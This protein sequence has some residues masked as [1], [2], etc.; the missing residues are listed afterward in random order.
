MHEKK[1]SECLWKTR[2]VSL[3]LFVSLN[4]SFQDGNSS[5]SVLCLYAPCLQ[6]PVARRLTLC[7]ESEKNE[8]IGLT[9]ELGWPRRISPRVERKFCHRSQWCGSS[10]FL[11]YSMTVVIFELSGVWACIPDSLKVAYLSFTSFLAKFMGSTHGNPLLK[12]SLSLNAFW[13]PWMWYDSF[14]VELNPCFMM[15][16]EFVSQMLS[17]N[18]I[19]QLCHGSTYVGDRSVSDRGSLMEEL[20]WIS[21][22]SNG[23]DGSNQ[24]LW[25]GEVES[26]ISQKSASDRN[27]ELLHLTDYEWVTLLMPSWDYYQGLL[28]HSWGHHQAVCRCSGTNSRKFFFERGL[29]WMEEA[30]L[31]FAL[32]NF[33][34]ASMG[35]D[36]EEWGG[37]SFGRGAEVS[38]A[39]WLPR[40]ISS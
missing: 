23:E 38:V 8:W 25:Q 28:W 24:C 37:K 17:F 14:L 3:S 40:K 22:A 20:K 39:P 15:G 7:V 21:Q 32:C 4:R 6:S 29:L 12:F 35:Y 11:S 2:F 36:I 26:A 10:K 13:V 18:V 31:F 19:Q 1:T 30:T 34:W 5:G 16:E 27:H 33:K 9:S